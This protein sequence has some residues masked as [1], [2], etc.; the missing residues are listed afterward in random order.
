[1]HCNRHAVVIRDAVMILHQEPGAGER[2]AP[3][4]SLLLAL[5]FSFQYPDRPLAAVLPQ[6]RAALLKALRFAFDWQ[7][8]VSHS[9]WLWL[10]PRSFFW[11]RGLLSTP[12]GG[13]PTGGG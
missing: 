10:P 2:L 3:A 9:L 11:E 6:V 1:M 12:G 7:V 8:V 13:A 4:G 5:I